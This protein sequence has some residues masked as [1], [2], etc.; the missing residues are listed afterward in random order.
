[1]DTL[2]DILEIAGFLAI[3]IGGSVLLA[4][5]AIMYCQQVMQ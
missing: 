2:K 5:P 4:I 1:M 3:M